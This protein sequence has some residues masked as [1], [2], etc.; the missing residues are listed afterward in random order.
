MDR[1]DALRVFVAVAEEEGFAAAARRL[2]LSPPA[3]TRAIAACER[4]LGVP[5]LSRTT[6]VVRLT[7]AGARFLGDARAWLGAWED[8]ASRAADG[9]A[10]SSGRLSVTA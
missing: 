2:G 7:D 4:E 10:A 1:V 8:M 6:R 9:A 5:L 3:V